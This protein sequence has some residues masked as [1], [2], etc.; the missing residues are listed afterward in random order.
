MT[1]RHV[2]P[3]GVDTV[4]VH[5]GRGS[6]SGCFAAWAKLPSSLDQFTVH[7]IGY[8]DL[9]KHLISLLMSIVIL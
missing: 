1:L 4:E 9:M 2:H 8:M 5:G 3:V 6:C 7:S